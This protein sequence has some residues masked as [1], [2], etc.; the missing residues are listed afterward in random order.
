[1]PRAHAPPGYSFRI[2]HGCYSQCSPSGG[3]VPRESPRPQLPGLPVASLCSAQPSRTTPQARAATM[4][5]IETARSSCPIQTVSDQSNHSRLVSVRLARPRPS[6]LPPVR[7]KTTCP[8]L[9]PARSKPP[10][11]PAGPTTVPPT[12]VRSIQGNEAQRGRTRG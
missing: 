11:R 2:R 10:P 7:A 4:G 12:P 3:A 6:T 5:C 9:S 8:Q 1:M